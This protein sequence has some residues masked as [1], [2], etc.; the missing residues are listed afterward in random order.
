MPA[1]E[2]TLPVPVLEAREVVKR[3][4]MHGPGGHGKEV[5]AVEPTSLALHKGRIT[6]LVGESGSGKSTLARMLALAYPPT[7]GEIRLDGDVVKK[8]RTAKAK[9]AYY[10]QVQMIFQDPFSSLSPVHKIRYILSR[11]SNCTASRRAPRTRSARSSSS[12]N[13]STSHRPTSSSTSSPTSSPAASASASPSPARS[14]PAPRCSSATNRSPCWTSPSAWTSSTCSENS[15]T[16]RAWRSSTSPTTSPAPATSPTRSRSCTRVS[17][18]SRTRRRD[19]G[20]PSTPLHQAS[21]G[22][23][24]RPRPWRLPRRTGRRRRRRDPR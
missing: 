2:V 23:G 5:K 1:P 24:P 12:S 8:A 19:R 11:P 9:R 4:P 3:F 20:Q 22:L 14:P 17:S 6:A 16:T 18:W 21:V 15:A 13:A 7:E 10:R